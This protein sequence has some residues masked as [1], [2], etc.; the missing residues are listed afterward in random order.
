MRKEEIVMPPEAAIALA[1]LCLMAGT[2]LT[3]FSRPIWWM[4]HRRRPDG[5]RA[6]VPARYEWCLRI[7]GILLLLLAA[8]VTVMSATN[9]FL[10]A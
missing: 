5:S 3:W 9:T 4:L 2:L 10:F 1:V 6:G 7:P 8:V